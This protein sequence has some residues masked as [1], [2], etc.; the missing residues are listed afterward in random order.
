MKALLFGVLALLVAAPVSAQVG[1]EPD[2][3]PYADLEYKQEIT[4]LF[5]YVLARSDVAGAAPK[6]AAVAGL[7][8]EIYLGGPVSFSTDLSRTFSKRDVIDPTQPRATRNQGAVSSPVYSLDLAAVLSLTGRKSWHHIVP[9][10]RAGIGLMGSEGR[11]ATSGYAFGTPFAF[12]FGG[13]L[14]FVPGG[15]MQIRADVTNRLFKL[16]YPE[17]FYRPSTDNT[18]VLSAGT[19]RSSYTNHT[20]LT[21]GVS[22]PFAR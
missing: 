2:E 7:R 20:A 17:S 5:G 18:A 3:S 13:G 19:P 16:R 8:Y 9:Q 4:P 1:H 11:D 6:S 10:I 21:V 12:S 15:R 14:K 22:Y